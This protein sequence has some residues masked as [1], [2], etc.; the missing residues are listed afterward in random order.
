MRKVAANIT[1]INLTR[2]P[3]SSARRPRS[4]GT[5]LFPPPPGSHAFL[6]SC[7]RLHLLLPSGTDARAPVT[8]CFLSESLQPGIPEGAGSGVHASKKSQHRSMLHSEAR[9]K[10]R[11]CF[12]HCANSMENEISHQPQMEALRRNWVHTSSVCSS[13]LLFFENPFCA[14]CS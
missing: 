4:P 13:T 6:S 12:P 5:H 2:S 10:A 3:S 11:A 7:P 14:G 9:G 8:S 1:S